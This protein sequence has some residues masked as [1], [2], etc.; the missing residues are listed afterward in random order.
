ME[1]V[2]VVVGIVVRTILACLAE[3]G[4]PRAIWIKRNEI[5]RFTG[6]FPAFLIEEIQRELAMQ[7]VI[8]A[9]VPGVGFLL[10]DPAKFN[11]VPALCLTPSIQQRRGIVPTPSE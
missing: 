6:T 7:S 3:A 4:H 10:L 2:Q 11:D 1:S 5:T 8:F 9:E